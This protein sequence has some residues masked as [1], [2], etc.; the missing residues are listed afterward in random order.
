MGG[1]KEVWLASFVPY[2]S[3]LIIGWKDMVVTG[4]PDTRFFQ[5]EGRQQSFDE[6]MR[7]DGGYDQEVS[8]RLIKQDYLTIQKLSL[9]MHQKVRAVL[10]YNSGKIRFVGVHNGLDVRVNAV[11]GGGKSDFNGYELR[12]S[13]I[14]P[15]QAP[16]LLAFP[17]YGL[18]DNAVGTGCLLA[19]SSNPSSLGVLISDCN[20]VQDISYSGAVDCFLAGSS[21]ASSSNRIN[22]ECN[23]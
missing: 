15:S 20:V 17:G 22:S 1:I 9:L 14:E 21:Q 23:G 19:S 12:L 2:A 4:F 8:L 11:S 13:G 6:T 7:E 18:F 5:Y 3:T 10:V 16:F